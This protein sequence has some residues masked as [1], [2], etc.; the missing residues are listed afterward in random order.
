M[1]AVVIGN[2]ERREFFGF[3]FATEELEKK[4][5]GSPGGQHGLPHT[6]LD[7]LQVVK[8]DSAIHDGDHVHLQIVHASTSDAS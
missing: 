5:A 4:G 7:L 2:A 3:G 1:R 6:E 8:L